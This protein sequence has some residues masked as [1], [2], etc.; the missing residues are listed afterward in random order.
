MNVWDF[1][2]GWAIESAKFGLIL[3]GIYFFVIYY[4]KTKE[5][6]NLFRVMLLVSIP[7]MFLTSIFLPISP[8][9]FLYQIIIVLAAIRII[10]KSA[11]VP[12]ERPT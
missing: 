1:I 8:A 3:I 6:K 10:D 7:T 2:I 12:L 5:R 11:P 9:S 4:I